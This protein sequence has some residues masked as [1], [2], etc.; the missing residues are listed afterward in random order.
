MN[1]ASSLR[2]KPRRRLSGRRGFSLIELLT[3]ITVMG[4]MMTIALPYMRVSPQTKVRSAGRDLVRYLEVIRTRAL[5]T[6]KSVRL[7]F[8]LADGSYTAYLDDD[9]D[10]IFL[11]TVAESQ[12]VGI[13]TRSLRTR[14]VFD[15]G[16]ASELP[17]YPGTGPV[18][19]AN[20]RVEFNTRGV[21]TP[22]GVRG[23]VYI[24][25]RDDPNAVAAVSISGSASFKVWEY[26]DGDWQ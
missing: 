24:M 7:T 25:Y 16:N 23:V 20:N 26:R 18:T 4:I 1:L 3:V 5:S 8:D 6:K 17:N 2:L 15:M 22:F 12:A 10:Q 19:F 9:R 11:Q 21:T 13:G 14:T